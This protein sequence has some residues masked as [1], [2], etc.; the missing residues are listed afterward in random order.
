MPRRDGFF[1]REKAP[2]NR[3]TMIDQCGASGS[4]FPDYFR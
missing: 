3:K 4:C 2:G 1:K